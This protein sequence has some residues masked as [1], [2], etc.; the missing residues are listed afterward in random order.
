[1][2]RF[3]EVLS[4]L[5]DKHFLKRSGWAATLCRRLTRRRDVRPTPAI[6]AAAP[7]DHGDAGLPPYWVDGDACREP[8]GLAGLGVAAFLGGA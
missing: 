2:V 5:H 7:V 4:G 1:M 6:L 3:W 8:P